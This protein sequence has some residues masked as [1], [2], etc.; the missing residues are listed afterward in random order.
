MKLLQRVLVLSFATAG[1]AS[2]GATSVISGSEEYPEG[3]KR[4]LKALSQKPL[5]KEDTR[6]KLHLMYEKYDMDKSDRRHLLFFQTEG[7]GERLIEIAT[8][9]FGNFGQDG[10]FEDF[11]Q[12]DSVAASLVET[13]EFLGQDNG[14]N[15]DD[16]PPGAGLSFIN[17][18]DG[19]DDLLPVVDEIPT[20]PNGSGLP[21]PP[22][23][24][25]PTG[26]IGSG[27]P[28]P[29]GDAGND[30][31]SE[32]MQAVGGN[33]FATTSTRDRKQAKK[34]GK[35]RVRRRY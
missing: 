22:G 14:G 23:D 16:L 25:G 19:T 24:A 3:L 6:R 29:P 15:V 10:L 12:E 35:K 20:G 18:G 2:S 31:T 32:S 11:G 8:S 34:S 9:L 7:L 21:L 28:L 1:A 27:L 13:L 33:T 4:E 17:D 30:A 5:S 26:P